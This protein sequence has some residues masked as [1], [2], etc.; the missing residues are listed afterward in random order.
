ML[1]G[2]NSRLRTSSVT[3]PRIRMKRRKL[4]MLYFSCSF[5]G[6]ASAAAALLSL[7]LAIPRPF[8]WGRAAV[9]RT[10]PGSNPRHV[11]LGNAQHLRRRM[12]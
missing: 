3:I 9:K 11:S 8:A 4:Q 12:R 1:N 6:G 2:A 10:Q 7:S 5:F